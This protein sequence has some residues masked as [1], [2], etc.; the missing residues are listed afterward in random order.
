[1]GSHFSFF[2][3]KRRHKKS[4]ASGPN[5]LQTPKQAMY[6]AWLPIFFIVCLVAS[7]DEW[8]NTD[9]ELNLHK[10]LE[11]CL[12]ER[13]SL[14]DENQNLRHE[15]ETHVE[16]PAV[17]AIDKEEYEDLERKYGALLKQVE[18]TKTSHQN[19]VKSLIKTIKEHKEDSEKF[20]KQYE[21]YRDRFLDASEKYT[22]ADRRLREME[23]ASQHTYVNIT[24]IGQDTARF[25]GKMIDK[26]IS[27]TEDMVENQHIMNIY[28]KVVVPVE[29]AIKI[30]YSKHISKHVD[31]LYRSLRSFPAFEGARKSSIY[32]LR[33]S[34]KMMLK[35][36]EITRGSKVLR[37]SPRLVRLLFQLCTSFERHS[38]QYVDNAV[39][40]V[41]GYSV[42]RLLV[43]PFLAVIVFAFKRVL[44]QEKKVDRI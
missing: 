21:S 20:K 7:A 10:N 35:Y 17:C 42:W 25:I 29:S 22:K 41:I 4:E 43:L 24:L 33:D 38:Q 36:L 13:Q 19:R 9:E 6:F 27:F 11:K 23:I 8:G 40:L 26:S 14:L 31:R 15:I 12:S 39:K 2:F 34:S 3:E 30:F 32:I 1:M 28:H 18:E 37:C 5:R 16:V 44:G